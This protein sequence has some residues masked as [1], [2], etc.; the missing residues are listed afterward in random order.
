MQVP[1]CRGRLEKQTTRPPSPSL[2]ST[3]PVVVAAAASATAGDG[4][5]ARRTAKLCS[6]PAMWAVHR[7]AGEAGDGAARVREGRA[8]ARANGQR[9][10]PT[11]SD[12][13]V[14][15]VG[16]ARARARRSMR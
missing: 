7:G 1:L 14:V 16:D 11:A 10:P 6:W 9:E 5:G 13:E 12:M 2:T 3:S 15:R 4:R 8:A